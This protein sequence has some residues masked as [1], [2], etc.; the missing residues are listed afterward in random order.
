VIYTSPNATGT[1][2]FTPALGSVG[3]ANITVT[4]ND[5]VSN[6]N[7]TQRVFKITVVDPDPL[8]DFN[9]VADF[10][11]LA[12]SE[13]ASTL[14]H[15]TSSGTGTPPT[16]SLAFQ[17]TTP[18][19]DRVGVA[20]RPTAYDVSSA[21][22]LVTSMDFK[23][24]D[25]FNA[26]TGKERGELRFGFIGQN[27]P[28]ATK[29]QDTLTKTHPS[30]AL[31]FK[32]EHEPGVLG[33]ERLLEGE[34][35]SWTGSTEL[36]DLKISLGNFPT[37]DHWLRVTLTAVRSGTSTAIVSYTVDDM[38]LG[39]TTFLGRII[40]SGTF[41]ISNAAFFAD[42]S[43]FAAATITDEKT[44]AANL[45]LRAD[46]YYADVNTTAPGAPATQQVSNLTTTGFTAN[47]TAALGGNFA[48]GFIVEVVPDGLPFLPGNF[49]SASGA[50]GQ[51]SGILVEDAFAEDFDVSGLAS[52]S[53]YRVRV[54]AVTDFPSPSESL[55][56]NSVFA[57]TLA[58]PGL[59][60]PDWRTLTFGVNAGNESIAGPDAI[61]NAAGIKNLIAYAFGLDPFNPDLSLLPQADTT[62]EFL[63]ITYRRRFNISGTTV[64][65]TISSNLTAFSPSQVVIVFTS[66]PVNGFV[67][68]VA[69]DQFPIVNNPRRFMRVEVSPVEP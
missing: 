66:V 58:L 4:V 41:T 18:G 52:F 51:A 60:Y 42:N 50:T 49:I 1:L 24:A 45:T 35:T 39:G 6:N 23:A 13:F 64:V 14:T 5:G 8:L 37:D 9:D 38:G 65:P 53:T 17:G 27:T 43:V 67:T 62:G 59:E 12:V 21:V 48:T 2:E 30:I 63:R 68:V 40:E 28:N 33:K 19:V 61:N 44:S 10:N 3:T 69:E 26:T 47:W 55:A 20:I 56:L 31:R 29:P 7:T 16:G 11:A 36:K 32:V 34:V 22:H 25:V 15:Q 46:N 57:T 54:R